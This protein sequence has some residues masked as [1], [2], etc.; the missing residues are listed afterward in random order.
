MTFTLEIDTNNDAFQH[1]PWFEVARILDRLSAHLKHVIAT[2]EGT[3][4]DTNGN[5][6]GKWRFNED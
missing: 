5:T 6:V 3:L 2:G 4:K 1:A